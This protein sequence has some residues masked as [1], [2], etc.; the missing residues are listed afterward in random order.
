MNAD[1]A[2]MTDFDP[3]IIPG[4]HAPDRMRH[5][6]VDAHCAQNVLLLCCSC[7]GYVGA[8]P[9]SSVSCSRLRLTPGRAANHSRAGA[10][11]TGLR[12]SFFRHIKATFDKTDSGVSRKRGAAIGG[13]G[14]AGS[15]AYQV[16]VTV[17]M[18]RCDEVF[19]RRWLQPDRDITRGGRPN[20]RQRSARSASGLDFRAFWRD[21]SRQRPALAVNKGRRS[22]Q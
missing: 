3:F 4:G 8:P 17:V 1:A 16:R 2:R 7:T 20:T 15:A 14:R 10:I 19:S 9:S 21:T 11:E 12:F 13:T 22:T 6:M 5:A 18:T